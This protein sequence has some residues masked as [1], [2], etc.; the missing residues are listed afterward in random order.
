[1]FARYLLSHL[2]VGCVGGLVAIAGLTAT[3]VGSLGDLMKHSEN[4]W[5]AA[6]L[7]TVGLSGTFGAVAIGSA[8]TQIGEDE[9]RH[10]FSADD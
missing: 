8:I 10:L 7:F 9:V 1:M 4:G 5:L 6:A 2:V 3:D